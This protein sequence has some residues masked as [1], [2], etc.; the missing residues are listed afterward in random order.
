MLFGAV[1]EAGWTDDT[2]G[3]GLWTAPK[4]KQQVAPDGY[5]NC[6]RC[7]TPPT[8]TYNFRG[9]YILVVCYNSANGA[10]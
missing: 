2:A 7:S 6:G 9:C 1:Q 8:V 4:T 10:V 5:S 3:F